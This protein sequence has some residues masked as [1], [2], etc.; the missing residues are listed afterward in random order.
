M[1]RI[2]CL[3]ETPGMTSSITAGKPLFESPKRQ[4]VQK[5]SKLEL[6]WRNLFLRMLSRDEC[7]WYA[8]ESEQIFVTHEEK[9]HRQYNTDVHTWLFRHSNIT[10]I[11]QHS[12][13]SITRGPCSVC[14]RGWV[15][16]CF[17]VEHRWASLKENADVTVTPA[18]WLTHSF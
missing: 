16:R 11:L 6:L 13:V 4:N 15:S 5:M 3:C 14:T 8:R 2:I 18:R 1:L 17:C 10:L 12:V 9:S 7:L